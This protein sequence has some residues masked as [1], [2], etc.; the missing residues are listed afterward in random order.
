MAVSRRSHSSAAMV[1]LA[2]VAAPTRSSKALAARMMRLPSGGSRS[3]PRQGAEEPLGQRGVPGAPLPLADN[4]LGF[5]LLD[6]DEHLL[7]QR[8]WH[9]VV[10]AVL[11]H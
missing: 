4:E 1:L 5:D 2:S 7:A 9:E 10:A 11:M 8:V 6:P 3:C